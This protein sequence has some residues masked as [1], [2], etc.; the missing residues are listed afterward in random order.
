[1]TDPIVVFGANGFV[2]RHLVNRMASNGERVIALVGS[3]EP[4]SIP[5]VEIV[6]G[7]F[8]TPGAFLSSLT[9]ARAVIHVASRSTPGRTAGKPMAELDENLVPTLALLEALQDTPQCELLYVSSGGAMYGDTGM[10]TT[11]EQ[12]LIRPKSYYGAGKAAA[13]H[14][15]HAYAA[16][17]DRAATILRPSNLY[18]PGQS[19]RNGFGII[20]TAFHRIQSGEALD[21]WGNGSAVRDYL[22][23][24]DFIALC[25]QVLSSPMPKGVQLFNA[26]RGEGVSLNTLIG[27]IQDVT[28][29][30]LETRYDIS[31]SVDVAKIV[32]NSDKARN[33]FDWAP[34]VS[35]SEGI[36]LTWQ[37]WRQNV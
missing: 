20:P 22:F 10:N 12:D 6:A 37:W 25:L 8:D 28:G 17:Y 21:I 30:Q 33:Q 15:I 2:G 36:S 16:Q 31:R 24:D 13:E 27:M 35:L 19:M 26:A 3:A 11:H 34:H 32:L 23:I 4:Y 1:M 29:Q 18:G 14:F 5:N 7:S 9:K